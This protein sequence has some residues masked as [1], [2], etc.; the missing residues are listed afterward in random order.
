MSLSWK[1]VYCRPLTV[2]VC[3]HCYSDMITAPWPKLE[4]WN[5]ANFLAL[6]WR[7]YSEGLKILLHIHLSSRHSSMVSTA[8]CYQLGPKFK[9]QQWREFINFWL[10][11]KFNYV[12]FEYHHRVGLW[13][14][15]NSIIFSYWQVNPNPCVI[16]LRLMTVI[17]H[18]SSTISPDPT[19]QLPLIS[20]HWKDAF[21]LEGT[22]LKKYSNSFWPSMTLWTY[23]QSFFTNP[24]N[25]LLLLLFLL[26]F[27]I[28][29]FFSTLKRCRL[30]VCLWGL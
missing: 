28:K 9:S 23:F 27:Q 1:I 3:F 2:D 6:G 30:L 11:R 15:W 13:T 12:K 29:T 5:L 25:S 4:F 19:H 7:P 20:T 16:F 26:L 10:K 18:I 8:A 22:T 17:L 21:S 14:N 24:Q